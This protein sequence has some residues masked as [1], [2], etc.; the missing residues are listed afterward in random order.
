MLPDPDLFLEDDEPCEPYAPAI[1]EVHPMQ[2]TRETPTIP[3]CYWMRCRGLCER[4]R[5]PHVVQVNT[6][7]NEYFCIDS[8]QPYYLTGNPPW[9]PPEGTEWYG[10]ITPPD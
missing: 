8:D 10:P 2:W 5:G 1:L 3:G 9:G 4:D 6:K 7:A